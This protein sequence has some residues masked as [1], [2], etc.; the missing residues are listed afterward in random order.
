MFWLAYYKMVQKLYRNYITSHKFRSQSLSTHY[1]CLS[2][3][4]WTRTQGHLFRKRTKWFWVRV[5]L[6]SL[7]LQISRLLRARISWHSGNYRV[8]IHS[9]TRTWHDRNIQSSSMLFES[10]WDSFLAQASV[11]LLCQYNA[12]LSWGEEPDS[13]LQSGTFQ[14]FQKFFQELSWSQ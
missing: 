6:Q 13:F 3:C 12:I 8:W 2:D 14:K 7:K 1:R 9:E 5:Q 4:N 10:I 11:L